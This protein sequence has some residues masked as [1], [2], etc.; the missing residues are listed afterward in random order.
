MLHAGPDLSRKKIDVCLLS[1]EGELVAEFTS[2]PDLSGLRALARRV[3]EHREPVRAVI[4]SMT[5]A[6]FCHDILERQGWDVLTADAQRVKGLAPVACKTDRIDAWVLALL[7]GAGGLASC[8][9]ARRERELARFRLHL[10]KH[11]SALKS[12]IHPT[13]INFGVLARALERQRQGRRGH[14]RHWEQCPE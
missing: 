14:R 13:L 1:D 3:A 5:G 10:A 9:R 8:P 2:P 6:R 11:R 12:R 4:E 7:S